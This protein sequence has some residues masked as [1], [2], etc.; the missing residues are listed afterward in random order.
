MAEYDK[1]YRAVA[2]K[3]SSCQMW[4]FEYVA[5]RCWHVCCLQLLQM[6]DLVAAAGVVDSFGLT[7][8]LEVSC[9]SCAAHT[10]QSCA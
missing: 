9:S 2:F 6:A 7:G 1:T 10:I 8:L 4:K 3:P 5:W